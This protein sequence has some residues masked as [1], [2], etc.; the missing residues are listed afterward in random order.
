MEEKNNNIKLYLVMFLLLLICLLIFN[1]FT[2]N[3]AKQDEI[4]N[5]SNILNVTDVLYK[6]EKTPDRDIYYTL[7]KIVVKYIE[8]YLVEDE[9]NT[10]TAYYDVLSKD[11][12]KFLN[13]KEYNTLAE[14][15]LKK[16]YV[17]SQDIEIEAVE[18]MDVQDILVDI[19][20]YDNN[21]YMCVLE[22]SV[23]GNTGYI[24]IELDEKNNTY[25][26]FYME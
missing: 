12:S 14:N 20:A 9:N 18:Y 10:W 4:W 25:S 7:D 16:F 3:V 19:Y 8:S 1:Y 15:F 11:Y 24:G 6:G 13:K 2:K 23:T 22:S 17:Y 21:K 5:Y 26:I